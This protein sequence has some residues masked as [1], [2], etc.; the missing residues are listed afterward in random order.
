MYS[1][2]QALSFVPIVYVVRYIKGL[3]PLLWQSLFRV[4]SIQLII[5]TSYF[6]LLLAHFTCFVR[7][8]ALAIIVDWIGQLAAVTVT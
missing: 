6:I 4:Y 7:R 1:A 8:L 3:L 5:R 2:L